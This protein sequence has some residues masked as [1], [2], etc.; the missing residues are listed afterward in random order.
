MSGS[1]IPGGLNGAN[2]DEAKNKSDAFAAS[3]MSDTD[4]AA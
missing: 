2:S 4:K 1:N 3:G